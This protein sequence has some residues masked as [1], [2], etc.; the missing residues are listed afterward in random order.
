[1]TKNL[2]RCVW[3]LRGE[4]RG[5]LGGYRG[6]WQEEAISMFREGF[7]KPGFLCRVA[8]SISKFLD[9][10]VQAVIEGTESVLRPKSLTQLV[11]GNDFADVLQQQHKQPE[12]L[13]LQLYLDAFLVQLSRTEVNRK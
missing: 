4:F 9:R 7:D 11:P 13:L 2:A 10:G 3:G 12:R 1:M 8:Q 6:H 5:R